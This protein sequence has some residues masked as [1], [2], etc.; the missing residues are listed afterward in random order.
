MA[1]NGAAVMERAAR[2]YNYDHLMIIDGK[3]YSLAA[4]VSATDREVLASGLVEYAHWGRPPWFC[5]GTPYAEELKALAERNGIEGSAPPPDFIPARV[6]HDGREP[7]RARR[8]WAEIFNLDP[9]LYW[10]ESMQPATPR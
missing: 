1:R 4:L 8:V 10:F 7:Y 3:A 2:G 9:S 5:T 6:P